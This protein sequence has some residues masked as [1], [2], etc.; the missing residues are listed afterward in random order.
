MEI[1][2]LNKGS[3]ELLEMM[4]D[5]FTPVKAA[6]VS[7]GKEL[8]TNDERNIKLLNYLYEHDH[9]ATLEHIVLTFRVKAPILVFRQ[10]MR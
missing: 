2:V 9:T 4:G 1:K 6:R 3:V 7:F 5:D 8:Y 10:W